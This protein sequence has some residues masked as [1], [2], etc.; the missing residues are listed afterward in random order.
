MHLGLLAS[1]MFCRAIVV[2]GKLYAVAPG[3]TP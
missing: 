3:I 1:L 2:L